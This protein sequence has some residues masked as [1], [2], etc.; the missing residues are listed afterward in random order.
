MRRIKAAY[1]SPFTMLIEF[2]TELTE[3][4]CAWEIGKLLVF[5]FFKF[6]VNPFAHDIEEI[7]THFG[8]FDAGGANIDIRGIGEFALFG[9]FAV[10]SDFGGNFVAKHVGAEFSKVAFALGDGGKIFL[11][12][13]LAVGSVSRVPFVLVSK[14]E[15]FVFFPVALDGGGI[16]GGSGSGAIGVI[17][18]DIV[19]IDDGNFAIVFFN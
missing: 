16:G 10:E 19:T 18:L 15:V 2:L 7:A 4:Y 9:E 5:E 12:K 13:F 14:K 8:F 17:T 3:F 11:K 6:S 1:G